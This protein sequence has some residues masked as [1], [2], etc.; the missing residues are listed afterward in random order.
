MWGEAVPF[1][2]TSCGYTHTGGLDENVVEAATKFEKRLQALG[3]LVTHLAADA[4]VGSAGERKGACA[5]SVW[6]IAE[7]RGK[8]RRVVTHGPER[9][10]ERL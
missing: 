2:A 7:A 4:A 9:S 3:Q 8:A 5:G 10:R 1:E 6:A